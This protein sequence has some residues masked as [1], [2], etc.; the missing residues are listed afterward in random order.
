MYRRLLFIGHNSLGLFAEVEA[1]MA[2]TNRRLR[3]CQV[4]VLPE[5][6]FPHGPGE[7]TIE[8]IGFCLPC[9]NPALN[10]FGQG[11]EVPSLTR[12]GSPCPVEMDSGQGGSLGGRCGFCHQKKGC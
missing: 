3:L 5:Q 11:N 7:E 10:H 9:L 4:A 1:R 2:T 8:L 6:S 12:T